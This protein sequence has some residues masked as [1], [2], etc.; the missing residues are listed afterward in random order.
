MPEQLETEDNCILEGTGRLIGD[1]IADYTLI[2]CGTGE[3]INI[4][5]YCGTEKKALWMIAASGW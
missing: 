1:N 2:H 3:Q 4:H 5:S